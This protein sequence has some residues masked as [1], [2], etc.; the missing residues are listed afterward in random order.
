MDRP[1]NPA[2]TP[3]AMRAFAAYLDRRAE[4]HRR[5]ARVC[6]C[7]QPSH[8]NKIVDEL[9]Y[10]ASELRTEAIKQQASPA[11]GNSEG[12]TR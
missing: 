10:V 4:I 8:H 3:A 11:T 12:G 9:E 1:V 7:W 2:L 5:A 6:R